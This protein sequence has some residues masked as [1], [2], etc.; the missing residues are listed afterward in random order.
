MFERHQ[1]ILEI[2][3]NTQ[4]VSVARL[5]EIL[6]V[7]AVT[8]RNDLTQLEQLGRIQRTHGGALLAE[9]RTRL[10]FTFA[11][12]KASNAEAKRRIGELAARLVRSSD[13]IL[14]DS[15]TTALA[16]GQ[17]LKRCTD[18]RDVT[19]VTT[20]VWTALE[21]LGAPGI[22]VYLLGG[23]LRETTGSITGAISIEV[24]QQFHFNRV[25][26]GASGLTLEEGLTDLP[27]A[28]VEVKRA[29]VARAQEVVAVVDGSKFGRL[30]VA[31]FAAVAQVRRVVTDDT[32]PAW[33]VEQLRARSVQ[34]LQ[35][36][37]EAAPNLTNSNP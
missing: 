4:S 24:L 8:I 7:S 28:E 15:S 35:T 16:V 21:M 19:L 32:A 17:A 6:S 10:E 26:L 18:L 14:L 37:A 1:K 22:Q 31:S 23:A 2:L 25:F 3:S 34:V 13:S 12:R 9:D 11:T 30:A 36:E 27:L 29:V 33:I 20:G 5:S